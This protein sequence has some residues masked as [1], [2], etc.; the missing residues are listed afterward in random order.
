MVDTHG[1]LETGDYT[2]WTT[3]NGLHT[4]DYMVEYMVDYTR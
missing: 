2:W 3:Y 4:V 1:G